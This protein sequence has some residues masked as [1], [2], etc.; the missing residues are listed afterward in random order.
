MAR[1]VEK[2]KDLFLLIGNLDPDVIIDA[3]NPFY[4]DINYARS[5]NKR[6]SPVRNK[7]K[8]T[9]ELFHQNNI[10]SYKESHSSEGLSYVQMLL[11][12]HRSS[13]KTTELRVMCDDIKDKYECI[14]I[15][16]IASSEDEF[17]NDKEFI[18]N[19]QGGNHE[20]TQC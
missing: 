13:G 5:T 9:L 7:M 6:E 12:G 19:T 17:S 16:N 3:S 1:K 10:E 2:A 11:V 15:H 18:L 20:Q 4:V 8:K 14:M